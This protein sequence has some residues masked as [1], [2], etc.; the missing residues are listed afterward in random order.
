MSRFAPALLATLVGAALLAG[1]NG[2]SAPAPAAP[3]GSGTPTPDIVIA[4]AATPL[5]IPAYPSGFTDIS[6]STWE[7]CQYDSADDRYV[8]REWTFVVN[9]AS[10]AQFRHAADDT[11]CTGTSTRDWYYDFEAITDEGGSAASGWVNAAGTATV[12]GGAPASLDGL[13]S[14][15]AQPLV[16]RS[17]F[18]LQGVYFGRAPYPYG[19]SPLDAPAKLL[20]FVDASATPH[21]LYMG[22]VSATLDATGYPTFLES[23][24]GLGRR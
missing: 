16:R 11:T 23:D 13:G 10:V 4:P 12:G 2:S 15:P 24:T 17:A 3:A 19:T 18:K 7:S 8:R 9:D 20:L 14:L 1:C 21:R 5:S 6:N 22:S